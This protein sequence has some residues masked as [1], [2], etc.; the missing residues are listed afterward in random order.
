MTRKYY[1]NTNGNLS[2][3][4]FVKMIHQDKFT[5]W[6]RGHR[7]NT[8]SCPPKELISTEPMCTYCIQC[9]R[10]CAK[11]VKEY[12]N[13]YTVRRKKYLKEDLDNK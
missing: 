2:T 7:L 9:F 10:E 3:E 13:H 8:H 6:L 4:D 11:Q 5:N 1:R 12:K